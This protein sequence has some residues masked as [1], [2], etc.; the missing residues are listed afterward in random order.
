MVLKQITSEH[1]GCN[2]VESPFPTVKDAPTTTRIIDQLTKRADRQ[3][4]GSSDRRRYMVFVTP[5]PAPDRTPAPGGT[6]IPQDR[7]RK[8]TSQEMDLLRG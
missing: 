3:T 1:H 7:V 4:T 2:R 6:R 5:K 8:F